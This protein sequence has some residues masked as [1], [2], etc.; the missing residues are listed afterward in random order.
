VQV[1]LDSPTAT[2]VGSFEIANTGG[3]ANWV[4][5][6]QNTQPITGIH[7]VYLTF[8][9]G[10]P[11]DF[12]NVDLLHFGP[13]PVV[14]SAPTPTPVP[15]I[16]AYDNIQAER[17]TNQFGVILQQIATAS[18]G[19]ALAYIASGDWVRY[20]NLDFG[21]LAAKQTTIHIAS[22]AA[23]GVSGLVQVRLDS[24]TATPISTFEVANT[25]GWDR[26]TD[27]TQN[28][29]PTTGKHTVYITFTSGQ[30]ADFINL[31]MFRF[32]H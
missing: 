26:W 12:V 17:Y 21:S 32:I 8:T 5:L 1:R 13:Q 20:D 23:T 2:P 25:G 27:L 10:Q 4:G 29:T 15:T 16:S 3:W 9:S 19:S 30:P 14:S 22:G 18:N 24:P 28:A 31:D 7:D 11:A 6:T